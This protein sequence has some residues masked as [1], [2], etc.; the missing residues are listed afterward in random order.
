MLSLS[1]SLGRTARGTRLV[2]CR[3]VVQDALGASNPA[4]VHRAVRGSGAWSVG[5]AVKL[6]GL[7]RKQ[8]NMKP[9]MNAIGSAIGCV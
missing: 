6:A 7:G 8:W 3:D 2:S 4:T 9:V 5:A 1:E